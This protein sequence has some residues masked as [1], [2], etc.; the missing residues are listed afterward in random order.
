M[1]KQSKQFHF[2]LLSCRYSRTD[3][4][5]WCD[6]WWSTSIRSQRWFNLLY[7]VGWEIHRQSNFIWT[8]VLVFRYFERNLDWL[9]EQLGDDEDDYYL[10]DCPG[11]SIEVPDFCSEKNPWPWGFQVKL[12]CI[13]M[14]QWCVVLLSN[15]TIGIF[16][17]VVSSW[18]TL[19]SV[20][21]NQNF[22]VEC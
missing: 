14:S 20:R 9:H 18:S 5:R 6:G 2:D 7:G 11:K 21:I 16:V 12:N 8:I 4:S 17:F 13:L 10:F 22:S 1:E 3:R 15:Y 19:N